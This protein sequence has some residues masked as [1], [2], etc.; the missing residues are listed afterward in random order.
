MHAADRFCSSQFVFRERSIQAPQQVRW[1][2]LYRLH[3]AVP[4]RVELA[5]E[6]QWHIA[7]MP[8]TEKT[9]RS[10]PWEGLLKN[11]ASAHIPYLPPHVLLGLKSGCADELCHGSGAISQKLSM[12][13]RFQAMAKNLREKDHEARPKR[14]GHWRSCMR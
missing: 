11:D 7:H 5:E 14:S 3:V 1:Q 4:P 9:Q 8:A 10:H 6:R 2:T 13:H 12:D